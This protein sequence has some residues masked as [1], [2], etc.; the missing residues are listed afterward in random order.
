MTNKWNGKFFGEHVFDKLTYDDVLMLPGESDVVPSEA[1]LET[2]LSTNI[3]LNIPLVSA[4]MDTVTEN[5]MAI[6]LAKLGGIGFLW[7]AGID[8]QEDW[9]DSVK[10]AFNKK[11]ENPMTVRPDNNLADV[12]KILEKYGNKFSTLVVVDSERKVVGLVSKNRTRFVDDLSAKVSSFMTKNPV[13]TQQ[14]LDLN[15]AYSFMKKEM[16]SKLIIVDPEGRLKSM[17]SWS[18]V[19]SIVEN[20]TPAYNRDSRGQLRVGASVGIR[21][22]ERAE[23]LLKRRCDALLVGTAHG[24][25][26]NVIETVIELKKQFTQYQFDVIAGNIATYE[27]A[28]A[29]F[30]AGADAVKVGVGPG[31]ICTTRIIA[32]AGCPQLS[33]VFEAS[34]AGEEYGKPVIADG[35]IKYSGDIAK[36]LAAGAGSVMIGSMFAAASEAPGDV[37]IIGGKEFKK[38]RGMGSLGAMADNQA[39]RDRYKQKGTGKLVPEGVEGAVQMKGSVADIIF[40]L[41][42]GVRSG[43]GYVGAHSI[44]EMAERAKFVK[45]SASGQKESHPHDVTIINQAPNYTA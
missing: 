32:G 12:H 26:K 41:L 31:S 21:D 2:R 17:Y 3:S 42:G 45:I 34:K 35:G 40:Q 8:Q 36:A 30:K 10:F 27:G 19:K 37:I 16:V 28:K 13:T 44:K 22:Y 33:A 25:S 14:D 11:I 29:L 20:I 9:V 24:H 6:E 5:I 43:M 39:S 15:E 7:R 38:Y 1:S 18:D 4:D 23:R